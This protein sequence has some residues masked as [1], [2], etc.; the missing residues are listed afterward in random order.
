[1]P[2][3][4]TLYI[5]QFFWGGWKGG[6]EGVSFFETMFALKVFCRFYNVI[7]LSGFKH[8]RGSDTSSCRFPYV[9]FLYLQNIYILV[10]YSY[11]LNIIMCIV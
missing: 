6:G 2:K 10:Q 9:F 11:T 1:M 5:M 4:K 8:V 3:L 7:S